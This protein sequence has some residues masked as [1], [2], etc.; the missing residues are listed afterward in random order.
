ML[1]LQNPQQTEDLQTSLDAFQDM[2][3]TWQAKSTSSKGLPFNE[4]I[5]GEL[6]IPKDINKIVCFALGSI[7]REL[8]GW[9]EDPDDLPPRW[10]SHHLLAKYWAQLLEAR[11]GHP[12]QLY[13]QEPDYNQMDRDVLT[14]NGFKIVGMHG[15]EGFALVDR[16]TLVFSVYNEA[17]TREIVYDLCRPAMMIMNLRFSGPPNEARLIEALDYE[18]TRPNGFLKVLSTDGITEIQ[19]PNRYVHVFQQMI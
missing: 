15:A 17:N 6:P 2:W 14:A 13:A 3:T 5:F 4:R 19:Y 1:K 9:H 7:S 16:Q 12:V 18:A 10:A 11:F 8:L